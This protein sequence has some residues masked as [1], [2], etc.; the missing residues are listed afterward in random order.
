MIRECQVLAGAL[1]FLN[2]HPY[3]AMV[4]RNNVGRANMGSDH[5]PRWV[6][7]GIAGSSDLLGITTQGH[8]IAV[9]C[10]RP[11]GRAT[12]AQI[13]FLGR[14]GEAGGFAWCGHELEQLVSRFDAFVERHRYG[15]RRLDLAV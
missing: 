4:W 2:Y 3:C 8:M 13:E 12:A 10:K 6:S 7:F 1:R 5:A 15:Q 9:E 11:G 14:V